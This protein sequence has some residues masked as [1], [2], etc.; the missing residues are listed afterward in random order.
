VAIGEITVGETVNVTFDVVIDNPIAARVT[1]IVNQ[2]TVTSTE[3]PP[4]ATD[5][6]D[7]DLR[8]AREAAHGA[9]EAVKFAGHDLS[10]AA[11]DAL[12]AALRRVA[13]AVPEDLVEEAIR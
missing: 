3:L 10:P 12:V 9:L 2:G 8:R 5:D 6:P 13:A 11:R 7:D 1:E 4:L